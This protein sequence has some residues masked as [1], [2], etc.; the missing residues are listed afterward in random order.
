MRE[1]MTISVYIS[2]LNPRQ[3]KARENRERQGAK[4]KRIGP[5]VTGSNVNYDN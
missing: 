4:R 2:H 3:H 1:R 5:A